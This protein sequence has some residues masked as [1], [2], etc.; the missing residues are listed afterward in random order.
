MK[1]RGE[2]GD[3]KG[4]IPPLWCKNPWLSGHQGKHSMVQP[5]IDWL[6]SIA[7]ACIPSASHRQQDVLN[8]RVV[9]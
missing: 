4:N 7:P 6:I 8:G 9:C 5:F 2:N 3:E 1:E